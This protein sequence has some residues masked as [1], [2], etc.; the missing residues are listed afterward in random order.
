MGAVGNAVGGA[1]TGGLIG[2]PVG[3]GIGGAAGGLGFLGDMNPLDALSGGQSLTDQNNARLSALIAGLD[4]GAAPQYADYKGLTD[5]SGNLLPQYAAPDVSGYSSGMLS[6][7]GIEQSGLLNS[8]AQAQGGAQ[9]Q[10]RSQLASQYG[11]TGGA[12]N[13]LAEMGQKN[14]LTAD[15]GVAQQGAQQRADIANQ[16]FQLNTNAANQNVGTQISNNQAQNAANLA[17]YQTQMQTYAAQ[18]QAQ[19]TLG[20]GIQG[21]KGGILGGVNKTL[22]K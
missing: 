11:L 20:A 6:K 22:G 8:A 2:G 15:Q 1:V 3:E 17:K 14:L 4:P 10:A 16:Q 5:A 12:A 18:K 21:Q 9:A 19:A 7:Q 13:R